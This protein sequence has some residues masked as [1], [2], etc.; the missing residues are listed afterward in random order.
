MYFPKQ[1]KMVNREALIFQ[2]DQSPRRLVYWSTHTQPLENSTL[3]SGKDTSRKG[4]H[5][6]KIVP[7]NIPGTLQGCLD[8]T[9][10]ATN[11]G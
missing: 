8:Y 3:H 4:Y 2:S 5:S 7:K 10:R 6:T 9:L 11:L 1:N